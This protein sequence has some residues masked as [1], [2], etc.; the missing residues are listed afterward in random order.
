[1]PHLNVPGPRSGARDPYAVRPRFGRLWRLWVP[2]SGCAASGTCKTP[3][4]N[5]PIVCFTP[6]ALGHGGAHLEASFCGSG[7]WWPGFRESHPGESGGRECGAGG[8]PTAAGPC[9]A[10]P[11]TARANGS[12]EMGKGLKRDRKVGL[13]GRNT[14]MRG[15]KIHRVRSSG[16][17]EVS[18]D[19]F[20]RA[21]PLPAGRARRLLRTPPP[22]MWPDNTPRPAVWI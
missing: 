5:I 17:A 22:G 8:K 16:D 13:D 2:D 15:P 18:W 14:S 12:G 20:L 9:L 6:S 11:R 4:D 21:I 10:F 3:L 1:M 19:C 7:V